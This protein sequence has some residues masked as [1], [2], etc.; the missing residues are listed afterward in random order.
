MLTEV[1]IAIIVGSFTLLGVY[2]GDYLDEKRERKRLLKALLDE[3]SLNIR[4]AE[5]TLNEINDEKGLG[6]SYRPLYTLS[7]QNIRASGYLIDLD[8][9][10]RIKLEDTFNKIY[11]YDQDEGYKVWQQELLKMLV[12]ELKDLKIK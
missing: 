2:I 5:K 12:K 11:N 4:V 7:Y 1:L 3:I 6:L 10:M 8:K 9:D